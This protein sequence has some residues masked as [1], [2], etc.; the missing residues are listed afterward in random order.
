MLFQTFL[1]HISQEIQHALSVI[2][3]CMNRKAHM[4]CNLDLLFQN[5]GRLDVTASRVHCKCGNILET[6]PD[7]VVVTAHH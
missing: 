1:S 6:V 5:E 7:R 4:A 3:L 2:C